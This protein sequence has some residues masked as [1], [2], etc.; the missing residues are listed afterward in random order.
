L[1]TGSSMESDDSKKQLSCYK[2]NLMGQN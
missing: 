1:L 2:N